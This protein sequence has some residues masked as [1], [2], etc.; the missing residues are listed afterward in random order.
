M[1]KKATV[2]EVRVKVYTKL[3][4]GYLDEMPNETKE[5]MLIENPKIYNAIFGV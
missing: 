5:L 4:S 2:P 3:F 1:A